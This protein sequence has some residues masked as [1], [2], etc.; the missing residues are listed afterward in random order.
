MHQHSTYFVVANLVVLLTG[1]VLAW[2]YREELATLYRMHV[3]TP[4]RE[5]MQSKPHLEAAV[6]VLIKIAFLTGAV[7]AYLGLDSRSQLLLS[8]ALSI[9]FLWAVLKLL[10]VIQALEE[11]EAKLQHRRTAGA[12][13]GIQ[14][15]A[16]RDMRLAVR[17]E[18]EALR[19]RERAI[20]RRA[21]RRQQ[22]ATCNCGHQP[23][24]PRR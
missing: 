3:V 1:L 19:R 23:R 17:E 2:G 12:V 24:L 10:R 21:R 14:R 16:L 13:R 22:P 6:D 11:E 7:G 9:T 18:L 8:A 20:F 5:T 4:V 15:D